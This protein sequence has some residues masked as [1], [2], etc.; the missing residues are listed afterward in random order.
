MALLTTFALLA[1]CL[2]AIGL[3]GVIAYMVSQTTR[4]IGVRIAL[5]AQR[6]DIVRLV[7]FHGAGL[8]TTGMVVGLAGATWGVRLLKKTL[9]GVQP[10]DPASFAIGALA[11]LSV[12]VFACLVPTRRAVRVDPVIAMRAE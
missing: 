11:L 2:S 12:A 8:A 10:I 6:M 3:Y 4:E 5:G 7:M 1:V 9:Y